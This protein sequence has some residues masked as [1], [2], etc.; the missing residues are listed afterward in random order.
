M[1][2]LPPLHVMAHPFKRR[3]EREPSH[4]ARPSSLFI[5][6]LSYLAEDITAPRPPETPPQEGSCDLVK[7]TC[8]ARKEKESDSE[9]EWFFANQRPTEQR[10]ERTCLG[11]HI[12][13]RA[14]ANL[15][16]QNRPSDDGLF[17]SQEPSISE[18]DS[19]ISDVNNM[20]VDGDLDMLAG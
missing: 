4:R 13:Y 18:I 7:V 8:H 11:F 14:N 17:E 20:E 3:Q 19:V 12:L 9:S 10:L 2:K 15:S 16:G 1:L 6:D 5:P